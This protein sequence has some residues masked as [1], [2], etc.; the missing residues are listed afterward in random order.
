MIRTRIN[1][2]IGLEGEAASAFPSPDVLA[3][4]VWDGLPKEWF[5]FQDDDDYK[6]TTI[7]SPSEEYRHE[8][9]ST[10]ATVKIRDHQIEVLAAELKQEQKLT[11]HLER[12]VKTLQALAIQGKEQA[13]NLIE[14][15]DNQRHIIEQ[16][17]AYK[18]GN[19]TLNFIIKELQKKYDDS[20]QDWVVMR[21]LRDALASTLET[22]QV[23]IG[24]LT[25]LRKDADQKKEEYRLANNTNLARIDRLTDD[26]D[27]CRKSNLERISE[28]KVGEEMIEKIVDAMQGAGYDISGWGNDDDLI[29]LEVGIEAVEAR[30]NDV[31]ATLDNIRTER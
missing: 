25:R 5:D 2:T 8:L 4:G 12:K 31:S 22:K 17:Q 21:D 16:L 10:M 15:N 11:A 27:G 13:D 20:L 19:D 14:K 3:Q 24:N 6:I 1:L 26:L 7:S 18:N 29:E 9:I 23:V 30:L 28:S